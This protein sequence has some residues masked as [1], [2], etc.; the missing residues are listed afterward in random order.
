MSIELEDRV[1]HGL[2]RLVG[3]E[4]TTTFD[5][6]AL[7][8]EGRR[9]R[10]TRRLA[11]TAGLTAAAVTVMALAVGLPR[12][13]S[14]DGVVPGSDGWSTPNARWEVPA[15]VTGELGRVELP[16][17]PASRTIE[18]VE[19]LMYSTQFSCRST[20]PADLVVVDVRSGDSLLESSE[21]LCDGTPVRNGGG[22]YYPGGGPLTL[23]VAAPAGA[24]AYALVVPSLEEPVRGEVVRATVPWSGVSR[25]APLSVGAPLKLFVS[26]LAPDPGA[27]MAFRVVAGPTGEGRMM[28][29]D[30][31]RCDG[32]TSGD[33]FTYTLTGERWATIRLAAPVGATAFAILAQ[34]SGTD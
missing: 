25:T 23:S 9:R 29:S 20:D 15:P 6:D 3:A 21:A 33:G 28:L 14:E 18:P 26:C 16:D 5:V 12:G 1:R 30:V 17:G 8:R 2:H 31:V 24:Q 13:S 10:R 19:E 7:V 4:S 11:A 27:R 22:T 32:S 34:D